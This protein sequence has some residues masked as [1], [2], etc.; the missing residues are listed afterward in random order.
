MQSRVDKRLP[1]TS[2]D[3]KWKVKLQ[4]LNLPKKERNTLTGVIPEDFGEFW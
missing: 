2:F 1:E 3:L 4:K